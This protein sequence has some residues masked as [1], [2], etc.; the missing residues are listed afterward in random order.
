[1]KQDEVLDIVQHP[2]RFAK[3]VCRLFQTSGLLGNFLAIYRFIFA[4][5]TEPVEKVLA[6]SR[7]ATYPSFQSIGKHTKSVSVKELGNVMAIAAKVI[8]ESMAELYI[9]VFQLNKHQRQAIDIQN[10]VWTT[11]GS[12]WCLAYRFNP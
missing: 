7:E 6:S 8:F 11:V 4:F 3:T 10:Y 1:M 9:R 2:R 5:D 12:F